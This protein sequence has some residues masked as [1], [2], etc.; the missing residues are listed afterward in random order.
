MQILYGLTQYETPGLMVP[1]A[2]WDDLVELCERKR[3]VVRSQAEKWQNGWVAPA[4]LHD[5]ATSRKLTDVASMAAWIGLDLDHANWSLR[6]VIGHFASLKCIIYSTT[7]STALERR[8]RV[9]TPLSREMTTAEFAGVWKAWNEL[10]HGEVDANTKNLNRL[11]YLPATWHDEDGILGNNEYHVQDGQVMDVDELLMI[12]P[13][14]DP[15]FYTQVFQTDGIKRPDGK[16]IITEAMI[17]KHMVYGKPSGRFWKLLCAAATMHKAN[18]WELSSSE[19]ANAALTVSPV[20]S[21]GIRRAMNAYR[22][23]DRAISWISSRVATVPAQEQLINK[24]KW[25]LA[26][27]MVSG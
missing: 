12:C 10:L 23:A 21:S 9:L 19:L 20:D 17:R 16:P 13:P 22:E 24:A 5:G 11:H 8:W 25:K 1:Q 2:T 18:D 3:H 14:E 27:T 6:Q 7:R 4:I 26:N 15:V